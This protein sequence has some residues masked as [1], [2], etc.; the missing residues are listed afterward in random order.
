MKV[1]L[2]KDVKGTGKKGDIVNVADG[3]GKNF[4]LKNGFAKS[5]DSSA[6]NENSLQKQAKAFHAEEE[7]KAAVMLGEKLKGYTLTVPVKCGENGKIFGAVT[8]KEVSDRLKEQG[9]DVDKKHIIIDK[10]IKTVGKVS[11][12]LKLHQTVSIKLD[13]EIVAS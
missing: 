7:R 4:L 3:F 2:L 13:V 8:S 11:I 10:P 6:I 5:A 1:V 9:F 12:T